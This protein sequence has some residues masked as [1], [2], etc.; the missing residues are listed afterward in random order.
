MFTH[1]NEYV[2]PKRLLGRMD[3]S[4]LIRPASEALCV[5]SL[6]IIV[7]ALVSFGLVNRSYRGERGVFAQSIWPTSGKELLNIPY[8]TG[9]PGPSIER[10]AQCK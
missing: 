6:G 5:N 3:V 10:S 7:S 8:G 2:D 1:G 9:T 4:L